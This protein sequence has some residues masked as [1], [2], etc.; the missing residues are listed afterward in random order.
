MKKITLFLL[1]LVVV[2]TIVLSCA[3][4]DSKPDKTTG[5][6]YVKVNFPTSEN[7]II[8]SFCHPDPTKSVTDI[9]LEVSTVDGGDIVKTVNG[10]NNTTFDCGEFNPG[11]YEIAVIGNYISGGGEAYWC[12]NGEILHGYMNSE[13]IQIIANQDQTITLDQVR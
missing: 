5:H 3:K 4:S 12:V 13:A 2:S 7:T 8:D 6:I 11:F 1:S 9:K 10:N